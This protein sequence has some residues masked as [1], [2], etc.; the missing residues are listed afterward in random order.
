MF[1]YLDGCIAYR[2]WAGFINDPRC[3]C[4]PGFDI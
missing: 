1:L 3:H 4:E 2:I